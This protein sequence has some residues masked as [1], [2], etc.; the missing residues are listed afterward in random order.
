MKRKIIYL[1]LLIVA[2]T[3]LACS[4]EPPSVRVK[5]DRNEKVNIQVKQ[6]NDNT[7]NFND[8]SGGSVTGYRDIAEGTCVATAVIQNEEE[9]PSISFGASNDN[10]YTIVIENGNPP[11][12]R[13]DVESK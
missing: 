3:C 12:L 13:V 11:K 4:E 2:V 5:N 6:S 7:I 8:V 10:Y 9:S 1:V